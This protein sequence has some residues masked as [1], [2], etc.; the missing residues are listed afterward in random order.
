VSSD[1]ERLLDASGDLERVGV[2]LFLDRG[3][4]RRLHIETAV[5]ALERRA[6]LHIGNREK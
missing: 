2:R 1:G 4:D 5:T 6:G 3:D